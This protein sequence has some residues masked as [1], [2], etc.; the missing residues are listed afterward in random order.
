MYITKG[1][2]MFDIH[3]AYHHVDMFPSHRQYL[4]FSCTISGRKMY[5]VFSALP[6]GLGT[7]PYM[8]TKLTRPLVTKWRGVGKRI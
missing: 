3:S 8:S 7:A 1:C 5:F 4:G 6:F 2:W